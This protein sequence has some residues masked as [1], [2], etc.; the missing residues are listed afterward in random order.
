[1]ICENNS[2]DC[3]HLSQT[4]YVCSVCDQ[5][6]CNDCSNVYDNQEIHN[7]ICNLCIDHRESVDKLFDFIEINV[8]ILENIEYNSTKYIKYKDTLQTL[9]MLYV[10]IISFDSITYENEVYNYLSEPEII[11]NLIEKFTIKFYVI[12]NNSDNFLNAE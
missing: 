5:E 2:C 7:T 3:G 10:I 8:H 6:V 9:R 12:Y 11:Y 4:Y 1:M